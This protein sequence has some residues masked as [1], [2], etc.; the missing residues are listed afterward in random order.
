MEE[1]YII[2]GDVT[3]DGIIEINDVAKLYQYHKEIISSL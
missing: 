3:Y 2:A 1:C